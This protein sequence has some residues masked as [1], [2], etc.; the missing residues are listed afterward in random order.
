MTQKSK[1]FYKFLM[2]IRIET[3]ILG[4]FNIK[5]EIIGQRPR[6][7]N[8]HIYPFFPFCIPWTYKNNIDDDDND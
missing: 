4:K 6:V 7:H 3:L 8:T 1:N 2:N 5:E